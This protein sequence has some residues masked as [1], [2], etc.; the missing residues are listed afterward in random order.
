MRSQTYLC[1]DNITY[2]NLVYTHT[3]THYMVMERKWE[4]DGYWEGGR[5]V[6][7]WRVSGEE[8]NVNL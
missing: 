6:Y 2:L 5:D 4:R 3:H 1:P 7:A 8:M